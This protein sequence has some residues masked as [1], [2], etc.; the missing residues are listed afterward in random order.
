MAQHHHEG[1]STMAF[2]PQHTLPYLYLISAGN[3]A[4]QSPD[5]VQCICV[6]AKLRNERHIV[7]WTHKLHSSWKIVEKRIA[8]DMRGVKG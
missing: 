8:E 3:N 5:I 1:D 2:L 6:L 7:T 4:F